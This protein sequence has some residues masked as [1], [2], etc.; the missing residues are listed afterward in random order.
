MVDD[1]ASGDIAACIGIDY[2]ITLDKIVK[3]AMLGVANHIECTIV[4]GKPVTAK[5]QK[6]FAAVPEDKSLLCGSGKFI[7]AFR[8]SDVLLA[9]SGR[10]F[11]GTIVCAAVLG[12]VIDYVVSFAEEEIHVQIQTSEAV[13]NDVLFQEGETA[14][15]TFNTVLWFSNEEGEN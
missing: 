9:K 2:I 4:D 3:G 15:M 13:K 10:G 1:T 11:A 6:P 5:A 12:S 8:P 14:Y 7:A